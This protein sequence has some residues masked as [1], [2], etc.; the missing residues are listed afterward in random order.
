ML[1][2]YFGW[3]SPRGSNSEWRSRGRREATLGRYF[4]EAAV[5]EENAGRAPSLQYTLAFDLKLRK[6]HGE[7]SEYL[8]ATKQPI[9]QRA[10]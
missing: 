6:S 9:N 1:G 7:I 4:G 5:P 10:N 3:K 8:D 2:A